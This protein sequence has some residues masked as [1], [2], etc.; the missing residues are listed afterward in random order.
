[1]M[2]NTMN[3][4]TSAVTSAM[5]A[6]MKAAMKAAMTAATR[7]K[8]RVPLMLAALGLATLAAC[9]DTPKNPNPRADV[10]LTEAKVDL[11][12]YMGRWYIVAHIPYF[13]EKNLVD[14]HTTF[15]LRPDGRVTENFEAKKGGFDGEQKKYQFLDTPD[16]ATGNAY[17]TISPFWPV[18]V[19][20]TTIYVSPDYQYTLIGYKG[21][22]LGWVFSR[23]PEISD[24]KYQE[25][26]KIFE[27]QGY[28]ISRFEKVVQKPDQI[29]KPGF[30][31]PGDKG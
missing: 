11:P 25:L 29:G 1:M 18:S 13:L 23:T 10:P 17:W 4:M 3:A 12:R 15:T 24:A 14:V 5:R 8:R 30:D 9:A 20:Q 28:D 27:Q 31:S 22:S 16:P 6:A 21:K 19:G 2:G 26:L 7:I